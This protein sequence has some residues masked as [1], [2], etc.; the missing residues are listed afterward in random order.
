MIVGNWLWSHYEDSF[1]RGLSALGVQVEKI[2]ISQYFSGRFGKLQSAIPAFGPALLKV[3]KR[4]V[5][6]AKKIRPD[7]TLF[8]RPT[9]IVTTTLLKLRGANVR[10]IS[11]NNDDPF[12]PST[13]G[14]V[15]WH[16]HFLWRLYLRSLPNYDL[17][18]FYR[19]VNCEE[20]KKHGAKHAAILLPYF[21][22]WQD[23]PMELTKTE[24]KCYDTDVVF[25]GHFEPDGRDESLYLL[26]A[27]GIKVKVWGGKEWARSELVS[28]LNNGMPIRPA[29]GLEYR[30][31]ISGAKVCICFLSKLNRDKYTRRCFEIPA[32]GRVLLA[33]RTDELTKLFKEDEEASFFSSKGELIQKAKWLLGRPDAR[34]RIAKGGLRRVWADHHDVVSRADQFLAELGAR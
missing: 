3:N 28:S 8:W 6:E 19:K 24:Q 32:M 11:Y 34:E 16:H 2:Q 17:N 18:F 20:A 10:T 22:P 4:V 15:P 12:G 23:K 26:Q 14:N 9:H 21:L 1:S 31:A 27:A 25:A 29:N 7:Y 33:E 5:D 13:H 30:K